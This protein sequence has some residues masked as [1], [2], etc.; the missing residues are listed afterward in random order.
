MGMMTSNLYLF[1]TTLLDCTTVLLFGGFGGGAG[2]RP[3][4]VT[5]CESSLRSSVH[6]NRHGKRSKGNLTGGFLSSRLTLDGL[7]FDCGEP[8]T[9][10]LVRCLREEVDRLLVDRLDNAQFQQGSDI[11]FS[12]VRHAVLR[13]LGAVDEEESDEEDN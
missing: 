9:V 12:S 4:R 7:C 5:E 13:L 10:V 11:V 8:D 6:M 3:S 2:L 1:D